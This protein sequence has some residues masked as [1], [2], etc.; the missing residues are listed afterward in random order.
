M[1]LECLVRDGVIEPVQHSDWASPIVTV[2]KRD[3][4][5]RIC[6]DFKLT[7]NKVT[8]VDPTHSHELKTFLR[9]WLAGR[10]SPSWTWPTHIF[11]SPWLNNRSSI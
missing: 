11:R 5:V 9:P 6:R 2:V 8:K 7:V 1:E 4:S 10:L 3:G